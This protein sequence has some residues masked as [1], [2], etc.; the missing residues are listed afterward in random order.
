MREDF[1]YNVS[2]MLCDWHQNG[3]IVGKDLLS[4]ISWESIKLCVRNFKT[5]LL[6]VIWT[7][8]FPI[9]KVKAFLVNKGKEPA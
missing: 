6:N 1:F 2:K 8:W 7:L 4:L 3:I 5:F 9:S